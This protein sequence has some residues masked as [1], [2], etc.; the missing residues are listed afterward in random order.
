MSRKLSLLSLSI[1]SLLASACGDEWVKDSGLNDREADA[2]GCVEVDRQ[3]VT[4][5]SMPADGFSFTAEEALTSWS[6]AW[7]GLLSPSAEE[8]TEES[9]ESALVIRSTGLVE[10]VLSEEGD[11]TMEYAD[12]IDCGSRYEAVAELDLSLGVDGSLM[13]QTLPAVLTLLAS[14]INLAGELPLDE[15]T[16]AL[17]PEFDPSEYDESYLSLYAG[18][19]DGALLGTVGWIATRADTDVATAVM[20]SIGDF[21]L[22]RPKE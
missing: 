10:A 6:G 21:V 1:F 17:E 9:V 14:S 16:G 12:G 15:V 3:P 11:T 13:E 7:S 8:K 18:G 5:P 4:D 2:W 20:E 22:A 19:S